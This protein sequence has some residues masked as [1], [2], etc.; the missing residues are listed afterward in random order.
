MVNIGQTYYTQAAAAQYDQQYPIQLLD[1]ARDQQALAD[2]AVGT[3]LAVPNECRR[4]SARNM[5]P[6]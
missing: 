2:R 5:T 3:H 4:S 1:V 6:R